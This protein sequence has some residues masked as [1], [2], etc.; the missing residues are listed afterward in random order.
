MHGHGNILLFR[1]YLK[2]FRC[3]EEM[4]SLRAAGFGHQNVVMRIPRPIKLYDFYVHVQGDNLFFRFDDK[5]SVAL[6]RG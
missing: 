4:A 5:N 2:I 6:T 1:F 3:L